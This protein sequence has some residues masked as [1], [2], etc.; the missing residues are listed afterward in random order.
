MREDE[1]LILLVYYDELVVF[2]MKHVSLK[3]K[4]ISRS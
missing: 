2:R 4:I 1:L 3:K